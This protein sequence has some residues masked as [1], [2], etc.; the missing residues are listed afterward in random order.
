MD[1]SK[2]TV[3]EASNRCEFDSQFKELLEAS[4]SCDA[5]VLKISDSVTKIGKGAF[6]PVRNDG[7]AVSM[8]I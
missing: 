1:S 2:C 7:L 4:V 5:I 8:S 6:V 3:I